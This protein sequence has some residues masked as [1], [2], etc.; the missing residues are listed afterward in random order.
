MVFTWK[1]IINEKKNINIMYTVHFI[2]IN[3]YDLL[4]MQLYIYIYIYTHTHTH[5]H[6]TLVNF[7][8]VSACHR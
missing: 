5:T 1:N 2:E 3:L 8:H 4:Y 6:Q 7:L